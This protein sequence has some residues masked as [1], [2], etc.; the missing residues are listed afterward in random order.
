MRIFH[1]SSL[2]TISFSFYCSSG[3][4]QEYTVSKMHVLLKNMVNFTRNATH[5]FSTQLR[6]CREDLF[7]RFP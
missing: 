7:A 4:L 5:N 3:N 6:F 1:D 2:R